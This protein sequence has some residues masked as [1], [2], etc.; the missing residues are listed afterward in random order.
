MVP[1]P[2]NSLELKDRD[3]L[4]SFS[5]LSGTVKVCYSVFKCSG[6]PTSLELTC[7][8]GLP[9]KRHRSSSDASGGQ[10]LLL[11]LWGSE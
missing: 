3:V 8:N 2:A 11:D 6:M 9:F 4:T 5:M 7:Q 10:P 1:D